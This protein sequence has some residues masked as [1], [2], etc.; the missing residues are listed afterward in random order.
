MDK[1]QSGSPP[2]PYMSAGVFRSTVEAFA[3]STT[4]NAL[5]RHILSSLSGADYSS[6]ISGLR[7]LGFVIGDDN[8][9]QESYRA[10]IAA[11]KK[12][13]PD[14][15][16]S[17]LSVIK[18]AYKTIV[19]GVDIETGSLRQLEKAFRDAGVQSGQM[20]VKTVRFYIKASGRLRRD[21]LA[22][23]HEVAPIYTEEG[24]RR[25]GEKADGTGRTTL[26]PLAPVR[27]PR[28]RRHPFRCCLNSS[29]PMR[30][31]TRSN[32][33]SGPCCSSSRSRRGRHDEG[34]RAAVGGPDKDD[35]GGEL[36]APSR[37]RPY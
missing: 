23:H 28:L 21:G 35:D 27:H 10:L 4:P 1:T 15:K 9:V 33:P 19:Q 22:T 14:Y 29:T 36:A 7:F 12:G 31:R 24:K 16:G 18:P 26:S 30:C 3:E 5:D 6:L 34:E 11:R 32:R 20:L 8:A 25:R 13:E 2:P 37:R 17:L